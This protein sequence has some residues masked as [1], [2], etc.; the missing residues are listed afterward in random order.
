MSS[1]KKA[2]VTYE[3]RLF[4]NGEFVNSA[5]GK[6]FPCVNPA[7]EEVICQVQ[8][9]GEQDVEK[10]VAAARAAF[11]KGSPWRTM[12]SSGRRDLMLK[13]ADLIQRDQN[14]LAELESLDN[15]KPLSAS[16]QRYGAAI[17]LVLVTQ[18]V[19]YYAGWSD[20][21]T[22]TTIPVD[23]K[24]LV[25]TQ[26][27]P[28]GV[29]AAII[30]WNF[31]LLMFAWKICPA[32][33]AGCTIIIKTSEK[34]P[35]SALALCKLIQEAGF[36]KGVVN[37]LS[38][39]GPTAG[40]PLAMHKDVNKIAF[41]GST[42][43]GHMIMKMAAESNLKRV[44][45]ELGGKSPLIVF[46]DC[47]LDQAVAAANL[48]LFM[49]HGQCCAAGSRVFVQSGIY[50]KFVAKSVEMAKSKKV[51]DPF[52]E[53][54]DQGPLVDD[55]QFKKVLGYIDSGKKEGAKVLCGGNRHGNK[56]YFVEPTIFGDVKDS[57][58]IARE[59]IFGPVMSILKFDNVEEVIERAN[60]SMYGLAAG[61]CSRD[62]GK[63]VRVASELQVF[64]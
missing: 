29:C 15:G 33:A 36:P 45:L 14:H 7:T 12:P 43:V 3:T 4:I 24:N 48:G 22:G 41:T 37:V 5:S 8:E 52:M 58:E 16:M 55:I 40:A 20:K 47:D 49:N 21:L 51:G 18:C 63:C 62:V 50:D 30:P 25:Y 1:P 13:L 19:R 32:L 34:T 2:K 60:N 44:T 27:E 28:V 46:D 23:G 42:Q 53:G 35:L 39:F 11:Q 54:I 31:P 26:R 64:S 9:A 6:T 56:G 17:D 38:G 57:M 61:I 59:E 10:A